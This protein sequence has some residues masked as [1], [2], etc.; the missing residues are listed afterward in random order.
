MSNL[1][2]KFQVVNNIFKQIGNIEETQGG[3]INKM[4]QDLDQIMIKC[5]D[6]GCKNLE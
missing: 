6:K 2:N 1:V 3:N 4:E 5:T